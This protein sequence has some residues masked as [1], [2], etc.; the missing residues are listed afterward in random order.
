MGSK[1][2]PFR[3]V[4]DPASF[5]FI[6]MKPS[7]PQNTL[8]FILYFSKIHGFH[9][10]YRTHANYT[11]VSFIIYI[12]DIQSKGQEFKIEDAYLHTKITNVYVLTNARVD[13]E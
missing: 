7:F 5:Y 13:P 1:S 10:S 8:G 4:F 12:Y 9:V 2:L 6:A 3:Y 11:P